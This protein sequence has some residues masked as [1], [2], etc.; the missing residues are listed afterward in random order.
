MMRALQALVLI[1][2]T[3]LLGCGNAALQIQAATA[4]A[5]ADS[6]NA[7]LPILVERYRDEGFRVL[8]KAKADGG[9]QDEARAAVAVVKKKWEPIW[10]AW[11][12]LRIA[13]NGWSD[14][15]ES[16]GNYLAALIGLKNA[17]CALR[18][19]WP[20]DIPAIPL[21]PVRCAK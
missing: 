2:A 1:L 21:G 4:D 20:D 7:A 18:I 6:S 5:V 12:T 10:K 3:L 15:L 8:I 19:V 9:N 11:E 14:A 16:S 17:Y 13:H